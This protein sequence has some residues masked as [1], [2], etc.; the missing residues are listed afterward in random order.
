ML[1]IKK[2][3]YNITEQAVVQ[4]TVLGAGHFLE[5]LAVACTEGKVIALQ[6]SSRFPSWSCIFMQ[7]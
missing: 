6:F 4:L 2:L 3:Y 7:F 1:H 5:H